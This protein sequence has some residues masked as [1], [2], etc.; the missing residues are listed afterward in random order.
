MGVFIPSVVDAS[1]HLQVNV[2]A[3]ADVTQE[4]GKQELIVFSVSHPIFLLPCS[5]FFRVGLT[6]KGRRY[7]VQ[8]FSTNQ[9]LSIYEN[10]A[11]FHQSDER[12]ESN[13]SFK[14]A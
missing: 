2:G 9:I 14:M 6:D 5:A 8:H 12:N 10:A 3:S 4:E 7:E 11:T 13:M 1:L